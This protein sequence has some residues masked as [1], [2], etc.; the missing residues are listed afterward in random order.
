MNTFADLKRRLVECVT[1]TMVR[2]DWYP[3][4]KLMGVPRVITKVQCNAIAMA[5]EGADSPS[6]LYWPK[7]GDIRITG[8]DEFLVKL[9]QGN[10]MGYVIGDDR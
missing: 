2:H 1:L 9:D 7:A 4:G 10:Y 8:D 3:K 6:W 5:A